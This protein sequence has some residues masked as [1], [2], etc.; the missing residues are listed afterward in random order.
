MKLPYSYNSIS[1]LTEEEFK[2]KS[3]DPSAAPD[4]DKFIKSDEEEIAN[5]ERLLDARS[6]LLKTDV[7]YFQ[8]STCECGRSLTMYDFIFTALIDAEHDKSFIL[9]TLIGSKLI[10]NRARK[11]RCS[12]CGRVS[13][14]EHEYKMTKY[15]CQPH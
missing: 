9:H 4:P 8:K 2:E 12:R 13:G 6:G 7:F 15:G 10:L 11:V 1:S 14:I 5:I 3:I